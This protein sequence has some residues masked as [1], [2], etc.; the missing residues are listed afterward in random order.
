[1]AL[2]DDPSFQP[3]FS[4][5][6]SLFFVHALDPVGAKSEDVAVFRNIAFLILK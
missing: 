3:P 4:L 5:I 2:T 1:L 6:P